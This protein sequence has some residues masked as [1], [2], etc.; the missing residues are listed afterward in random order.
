MGS[1]GLFKKI[2]KSFWKRLPLILV[3][4]LGMS[5]LL[6]GLYF[7]MGPAS[8]SVYV[9]EMAANILS[10]KA[11][12]TYLSLLAV[13]G[14]LLE[15][16]FR[17]LIQDR[18]LASRNKGLKSLAFI[19]PIALYALIHSLYGTVGIVYGLV[20]GTF[21]SFLYLWKKDWLGY[22]LWHMTWGFVVI[23]ASMVACV[24][25]GGQIRQD[26][27][28]AYKKKHIMKEKMYYVDNW[29]WVDKT[30]Y[31]PDHFEQV[32]KAVEA[33]V[34]K[35]EVT[36]GDS[37]VT[38]LKIEV[39]FSVTYKFQKQSDPM[40]SW[41][42][43]TGMMMHFMRTNEEVQESS[44][45]YHGNQLSAW[46]FDD[47]SSCLLCCL[48]E[49]PEKKFFVGGEKHIEQSDLLAIWQ[50]TGKQLVGLKMQ[51]DN[52]WA[53]LQGEGRSELRDLVEKMRTSWTA[54]KLI[55]N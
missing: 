53:L 5:V 9:I 54:E 16:V 1:M 12:L 18:L 6:I 41:A 19:V 31:R 8:F 55:L 14:F 23:P 11:A 45:W 39:T 38:P 40:K 25:L 22:S 44:P 32:K 37:W 7:I 48:D 3:L 17:K 30:H 46:Q 20:A 42:Q 13:Y 50:K 35:G 33:V 51:E 47:M 36:L 27:L 26:F 43:V 21:L 10:V 24:F 34:D 2:L 49:L 4:N 29:G 15:F 28:F 52:S